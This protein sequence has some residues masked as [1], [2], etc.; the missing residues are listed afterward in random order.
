MSRLG[1][2]VNGALLL[3]IPPSVLLAGCGDHSYRIRL[4]LVSE[5]L[6]YRKIQN[7]SQ[8]GRYVTLGGKYD[9][10]WHSTT[11]EVTVYISEYYENQQYVLI[12][13]YLLLIIH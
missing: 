7:S 12:V 9:M 11:N 4:I 10:L 13:N 6:V 8:T 5:A 1:F 2:S 3:Q